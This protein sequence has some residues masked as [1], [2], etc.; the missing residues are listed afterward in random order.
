MS[1][2]LRASFFTRP[3]RVFHPPTHRL[4]R[5]LYPSA[6]P[7]STA[8]EM[9]PQSLFAPGAAWISPNVRERFSPAHPRA[10]TRRVPGEHR[11]YAYK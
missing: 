7:A 5:N 3:T 4:L 9:I 2:Q 11:L 1:P 10:E 6:Y 8:L